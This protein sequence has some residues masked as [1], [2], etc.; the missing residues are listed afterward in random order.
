[1]GYIKT[2]INLDVNKLK[3][4]FDGKINEA[5]KLLD[6]LVLRD[7]TQYVPLDTGDLRESGYTG[8]E[9]GKKSGVG[10]DE[11]YAAFLYYG[12]KHKLKKPESKRR[13][14]EYA[15]YLHL[16]EWLKEVYG[17]FNKRS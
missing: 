11:N 14:F 16:K 5:Q 4:Q 15:K 12:K 9:K 10:W 7:S 13:W 1:M 8:D 6:D 17:V 2:T 3:K